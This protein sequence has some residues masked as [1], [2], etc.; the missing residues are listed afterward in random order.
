MSADSA[1][2]EIA[3]RNVS[4]SFGNHKVLAGVSADVN[5]G[6]AV[7]VIGPSGSGKTTLLR[8][9]NLLEQ[10]QEGEICIAGEAM[11]YQLDPATQ[12]R[13]R[14]SERDIARMRAQVGMVF[15]SFNLFPH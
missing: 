10:F 15:Q 5:K 9:I 12:Q 6:E 8:C 1:T 4:K 14:R 3:I 11:G 7:V 2:A 13:R